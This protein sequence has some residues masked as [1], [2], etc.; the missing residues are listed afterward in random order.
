M[1][2]QVTILSWGLFVTG[3]VCALLPK[4]IGMNKAREMLMLGERY[5][6]ATLADYGLAWKVVDDADLLAHANQLAAH[7]A[8]LPPQALQDMK[9]TLLRCA[10]GGPQV[11]ETTMA[12]ETLATVRENRNFKRPF[13]VEC[14]VPNGHR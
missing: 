14:E 2:L 3:G 4:L 1:W 7:L 5:D 6:A 8:A 9:Q 13:G 11:L 12:M 10:Y